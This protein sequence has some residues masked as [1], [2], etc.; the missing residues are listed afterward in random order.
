MNLKPFVAS[1]ALALLASGVAAQEINFGVI[2][3]DSAATQR[4]RL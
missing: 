2:A 4:E 3:T 1:M